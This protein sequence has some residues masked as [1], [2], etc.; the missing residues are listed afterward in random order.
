MPIGNEIDFLEPDPDPRF[1]EISEHVT[2]KVP[3]EL[4]F[5]FDDAVLAWPGSQPFYQDNKGR[6]T[7]LVERSK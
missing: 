7:F 5:Y 4:F 1:G 3:G 6:A 2:P